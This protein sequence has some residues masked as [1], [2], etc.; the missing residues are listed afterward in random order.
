MYVYVQA[1]P[2]VFMIELKQS[3]RKLRIFMNTYVLRIDS[4]KI[5]FLDAYSMSVLRSSYFIFSKRNCYYPR[6]VLSFASD[7]YI[8]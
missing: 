6:S 5:F 3:L 7:V 4:R 8:L 1:S 2:A